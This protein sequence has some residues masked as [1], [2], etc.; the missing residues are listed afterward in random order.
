MRVLIVHNQL[1]A[2]YKSKLFS[3]IHR[4]LREKYP[5]AN[6]LVAQIALYEASRKGMMK[7]QQ[8]IAY[9]YPYQVLFEKSLDE[10]PFVARLKALLQTYKA[11]R[12][13]VLNITGYFD[14]AQVLLMLYARWQGVKVVL[15]SESSGAD[16]ERSGLKETLK[17]WIVNQAHAYF[18]FG[19]SSAQYLQALGVPKAKIAVSH[20]AV[21]DEATIYQKYLEAKAP[22]ESG[23][24]VPTR[25]FIYVG[26]LAPEK[27]L[28]TLLEAFQN[29][30]AVLA[31]E[32]A[33]ELLLVGEGPSRPELEGYVQ[34][35]AIAHVRFVGG[36]AWYEVPAWLAQ[37][38]VLVLPS[39]SEPWGLVVNEAMVC[40]LPVI[41]SERCGCAPDLVEVGTNG[42]LFNPHNT[43]E[44]AQ[45]LG[46]FINN[47]DRLPAMGAESQRIVAAFSSQRVARQM[48]ACYHTLADQN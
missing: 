39:I 36:C 34:S 26:R 20:A 16:H 47:P 22:L 7:S 30:Q 44:L 9:Q 17:S 48:V 29:S 19:Q 35:R 21:V 18:C 46:Y 23:P 28:V 24:E 37:S 5:E 12:P 32:A 40:G 15:S 3:E 2:H 38:S 13:T 42:F 33:W 25:R 1:W 10:V 6:L 31:P 14:W 27:N 8:D 11:F 4:A 45:A 43:D 41:V